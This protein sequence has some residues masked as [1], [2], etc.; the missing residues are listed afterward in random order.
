M[1]REEGIQLNVSPDSSSETVKEIKDPGGNY[2]IAKMI[3]AD[4]PILIVGAYAPNDDEN[5]WWIELQNIGLKLLRHYNS[6]RF[7]SNNGPRT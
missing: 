4:N 2:L 7:Q 3:F 6:R 5:D 1:V